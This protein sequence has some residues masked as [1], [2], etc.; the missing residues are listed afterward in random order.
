MRFLTRPFL[1][2]A[3]CL[4]SW[5]VASAQAPVI[6]ACADAE[7]RVSVSGQVAR[8]CAD[9]AAP[10]SL[11]PGIARLRTLGGNLATI[12]TQ[13]TARSATFRELIHA[14]CKT[15][16]I[17]YVEQ[18][19]CG[20]GVRACL[21]GVTVA[22]AN[23]I[24]RVRVDTNKVDWDLMGSIGHELQHAVEV[25]SNPAVTSTTAMFIFYEREGNRRAGV[26]ET[27]AAIQAGD[28]VRAEARRRNVSTQ[29]R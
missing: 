17:V 4:F 29:A 3:I 12:V 15:N 20:H 18:G 5:G 6:D 11:C 24:V 8:E 10:V 16:G 13:A 2:T 14:I 25:L 26:F 7:E 9:D 28:D 1:L 21:L 27:G 19:R 23:R 22:G